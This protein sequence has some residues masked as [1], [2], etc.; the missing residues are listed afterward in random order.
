VSMTGPPFSN[1]SPELL[2][3][4]AAQSTQ[5]A[6]GMEAARKAP[7]SS[8]NDPFG[9]KRFDRLSAKTPYGYK[10]LFDKVSRELIGVPLTRQQQR[11]MRAQRL[12]LRPEQID[13][14]AYRH[15]LTRERAPR[16][17]PKDARPAGSVVIWSCLE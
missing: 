2:S 4:I 5:P 13:K 14:N 9:A 10:R 3:F 12:K 7:S 6:Q 8:P 15:P 16:D 17:M 1:T 11:E